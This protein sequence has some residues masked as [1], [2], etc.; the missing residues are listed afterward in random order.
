MKRQ[1]STPDYNPTPISELKRLKQQETSYQADT[2][3]EKLEQYKHKSAKVDENQT[4]KPDEII[5]IR[6]DLESDTSLEVVEKPKRLKSSDEDA[7][8]EKKIPSSCDLTTFSKLTLTQQVLKRYEMLNKPIP[9]LAEAKLKK[10]LAAAITDAKVAVDK[11][12]DLN[13]PQL[14]LDTNTTQKV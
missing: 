8:N 12:T 2:N 11:Q 13:S 3:K 9:Q 4:Q 6:S 14:I 5:S 1:Q 10:K 7:G